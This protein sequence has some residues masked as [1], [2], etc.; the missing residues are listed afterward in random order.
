M[1]S[2]RAY[3]NMLTTSYLSIAVMA[4]F[5]WA[6]QFFGALHPVPTKTGIGIL[7]LFWVLMLN[8]WPQMGP[9][10]SFIASPRP[11]HAMASLGVVSALSLVGLAL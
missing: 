7:I 1:L 4:A 9:L 11:W 3:R 6:P 10:H 2:E 5:W 8:R